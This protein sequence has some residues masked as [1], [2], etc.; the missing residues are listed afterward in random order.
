MQH[1]GTAIAAVMGGA[2]PVPRAASYEA[3]V[4]LRGV[5][6]LTSREAAVV[7]LV[8]SGLSNT[9]IA[10]RLGIAPQTVKN[11]L[12]SA[13]GKLGAHSRVEVCLW[14]GKRP[15]MELA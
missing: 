15:A 10:G 7:E 8:S 12:R 5:Q 13:M 6:R 9:Q 4:E 11:H 2:T 14:T 1:L 3:P